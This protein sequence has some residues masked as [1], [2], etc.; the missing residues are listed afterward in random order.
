MTPVV[1]YILLWFPERTQTFVREEVATVAA[2]G[3]PVQVYTMYGRQRGAPP[4][5]PVPVTR[6][7]VAAAG[8]LLRHLAGLRREFGPRAPEVL[9]RVLRRRWRSLETAAEALWA[10]LAGVY[11][12]RR[13][14][15][16]G[17]GHLHA[18]WA[19]G[20]ATAAWVAAELSGIPFS[21]A[22]HAHDIY[23][24]DGALRE[25]LQAAA[26]V[27]TISRANRRYL[28]ACCPAA[29]A[30]ILTLPVGVSL[31]ARVPAP[32]VRL[33]G[34]FR[35]LSVGRLVD[36]KG[37]P[38]LLTACRL[39]EDQGVAVHLTV[40]GDGPR[41]R[42]LLQ[43]VQ[44][45]G[46]CR[47]VAFRG[48]LPHHE[49]IRLYGEADL[50]VLPCRVDPRGDR[51]GIPT[52]LM[53]ALARELPVVSTVVSGIPELVRPGE[54]GWLAPP[55]DPLALAAAIREAL[56]DPKEARR[57]ARAGRELVAREFNARHNYRRMAACFQASL[58]GGA[59]GADC[60]WP[61]EA[62]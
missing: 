42:A 9:S 33:P 3:I 1:A 11:L 23:P 21:F 36:K 5:P 24:P 2:A 17:V 27:R 6:L 20:P 56:A 18:P 12:A 32:R 40:V 59:P 37:F 25:K 10:A 16:E 34:P 43:Q 62:P 45:L 46:L 41:R 60:G 38:H 50:L 51:D 8:T 22:A 61:E 54:T 39:L 52:V 26:W 29:A 4:A 31:P 48:H 44:A 30:K 28:A 35:L 55:E 58:A 53:E 7:G 49:V 47:R 15:A 13:A 14:R 57:R 19:D